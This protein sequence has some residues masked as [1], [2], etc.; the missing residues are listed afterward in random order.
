M[1]NQKF[2]IYFAPAERLDPE[3]IKKQAEWF[4]NNEIL[5]TISDAVS[6][7]MVILN[8]Q[9]QIVYANNQFLKFLKLSSGD[10]LLAK[11]RG[12]PSTASMQLSAVTLS[13]KG[14]HQHVVFS[15]HNENF[16]EREIQLQMFNRS[17]STKGVGHG[18]GTYSMKLLGEKYL[19]GKVWF[20]TSR[21]NGTFFHLRLPNTV[22][23][24]QS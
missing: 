18:L 8:P 6:K 14:N 9:R 7:M 1:K 23:K 3:K 16:M 22:P 12:K 20:T 15:V 21:E 5:T 11:G 13:G 19:K 17:F 2:Q 24:D 4:Q 10:S